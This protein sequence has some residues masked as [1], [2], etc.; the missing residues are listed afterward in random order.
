MQGES[1]DTELCDNVQVN[2][3][4]D[5]EAVYNQP[6]SSSTPIPSYTNENLVN[7]DDDEIDYDLEMSEILEDIG[8]E[9]PQENPEYVKVS[10]TRLHYM[11]KLCM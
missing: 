10:K 3:E 9:E 8:L 1:S 6:T 4:D 7:T 11:I 2:D 5:I